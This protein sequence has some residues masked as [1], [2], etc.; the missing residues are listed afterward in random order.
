MDDAKC[1]AFVRKQRWPDSVRCP[2]CDSETMIRD[3]C[4]D[5]QPCRQRRRCKACGG[6]FDDLTGTVLAGH[7]QPLRVWVLCLCLMGLNLSNRQIALELGLNPSDVHIMTDQLRHGLVAKV[8]EAALEGEVEIDAVRVVAGHKGQ[9]A[10]VAKKGAARAPPQ[11]GGRAG[12]RHAGEGQ[13]AHPWPDPARR[14][15]RAAHAG[16]R[17]AGHGQARSSRPRS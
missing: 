7:H 17:A 13:A 16:Q 15:G 2:S 9:P 3:G 8:P 6:R 14:T 1:F 11:A 10:A 12:A 5:T 4:D